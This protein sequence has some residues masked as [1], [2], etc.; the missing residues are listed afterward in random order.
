MNIFLTGATGFLGSKLIKQFLLEGHAIYLIARDI[1]KAEST[2]STL[3]ST[4]DASITIFQGDITAKN[5]GLSEDDV[6][7][8]ENKID[9]FYHLAALVKF[10][11]EL[12]E[13]LMATNFGG[14][15]EALSFAH[16]IKVK[17]FLH[18]S[19]AY[20][21]GT[22]DEGFE[23][24]SP[25]GQTYYNPYEESKGLAERAVFEYADKMDISIF[26]PSII[27]GDSKTG[28]ANSQ[29]TLY[30]FM[31]GL[32]LFKKRLERKGLLTEKIHLIGSSDGTS[33]LVPVDYVADILALGSKKA[34]KNMIYFITNPK[35]STNME[36]LNVIKQ[37]L[38]FNNLQIYEF[39]SQYELNPLEKQMNEMI[40]VFK[41]YLDRNIIFH[42]QNTVQLLEGTNI[43]HLNMTEDI[44]HLIVKSYFQT[45]NEEKMKV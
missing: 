26:R 15:R 33:N 36:I 5:L 13:E 25:K 18:V 45:N 24:L 37:Y 30:G 20:T 12:R 35:P 31:R 43:Q 10:D 11:V 32:D 9:V 4:E 19:T 27:V 39:N 17:K 28:E 23:Q 8:L 40:S 14:T 6:T 1:K 29:F 42:D 16:K 38:Q 22:S 44:L 34:E 41:P 3:C 2:L 7:Y 21:V